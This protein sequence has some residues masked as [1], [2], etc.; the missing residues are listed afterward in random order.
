MATKGDVSDLDILQFGGAPLVPRSSASRKR[1]TG[2]VQSDVVGGLTRQR[3]KYFNQPYEME[4]EFYLEDVFMQDYLKSFFEKNEGR[5]FI[6]HLA[7]DRPIVE[8][9]V[10]QVIS[11]WQDADVTSIYATLTV[12]L[13]IYPARDAELDELLID[14]YPVVG[15]DIYNWLNGFNEIVEAMPN[16]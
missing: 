9:Y 1:K 8:P 6:C 12:T 15:S 13:E 3:K 7:A 2:L 10:V 14:L 11:D 16:V 5:K 4:C